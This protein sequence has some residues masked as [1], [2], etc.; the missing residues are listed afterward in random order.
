MYRIEYSDSL[1]QR[2]YVPEAVH[3][4]TERV[5][6]GMDLYVLRYARSQA[7]YGGLSGAGVAAV[8]ALV[9]YQFLPT[10]SIWLALGVMIPSC[11]MFGAGLVG[12]RAGSVA[13]SEYLNHLAYH[14]ITEQRD[15]IAADEPAGEGLT[16]S[17][18]LEDG[19]MVEV[20]QPAPGELASFLRQAL[21]E[22]S[23][24]KF[25]QNTARGRGWNTATY[26]STLHAMREAGL[27]MIGPNQV[28]LPTE[29][30]RRVLNRWLSHS[31]A[32]VSGGESGGDLRVH[33]PNRQPVWGGGVQ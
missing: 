14:L 26:K 24:V 13:K 3:K 6:V 25:T 15:P 22:S 4:E 20:L 30:G 9:A 21:D 27:F 17:I 1:A 11:A 28:P 5:N 29:K 12:L 23:S 31:P 19:R 32:I 10:V 7:F 33:H 8:V 16:V 18:G 2:V